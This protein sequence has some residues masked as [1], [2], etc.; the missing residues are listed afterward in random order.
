[1]PN[2][3]LSTVEGGLQGPTG[4]I[5]LFHSK[6]PTTFSLE[7]NVYTKSNVPDR[8]IPDFDTKVPAALKGIVSDPTRIPNMP[9]VD[10][11]NAVSGISTDGTMLRIEFVSNGNYRVFRKLSSEP[12]F[13]QIATKAG[14]AVIQNATRSFLVTDNLGS[15]VAYLAGCILLSN[16]NGVSWRELPLTVAVT[17]GSVI[18]L[19]WGS[20]G[21]LHMVARRE[22]SDTT[23]RVYRSTDKGESWV[24]SATGPS[25]PN[26]VAYVSGSTWVAV[27]LGV[28]TTHISTD[29]GITW[30][31]GAALPF[32][33]NANTS[34][35]QFFSTNGRFYILSLNTWYTGLTLNTMS[36]LGTD[37]IG[38]GV[39]ASGNCLALNTTGLYRY[40]ANGAAVT[41]INQKTIGL[42]S[43]QTGYS[44]AFAGGTW[45]DNHGSYITTT[46]LLAQ[47]S[48][49]AQSN[50]CFNQFCVTSASGRSILALNCQSFL[51]SDDNWNTWVIRK[52]DIATNTI[53]ALGQNLRVQ[54]IATDNN[55][56]WAVLIGG[57]STVYVIV[58]S[59]NGVTW[60]VRS[61][62]IG[63]GTS[64]S[65]AG[66]TLAG[67][68]YI[69]GS[70]TVGRFTSDAFLNTT[71]AS[72]GGNHESYNV[73]FYGGY[74]YFITS[75]GGAE[76]HVNTVKES[77]GVISV[78]TLGTDLS[79]GLG[80][81]SQH[82]FTY[83]NQAYLG[84]YYFV[85]NEGNATILKDSTFGAVNNFFD[86]NIN[87]F[88]SAVPLFQIGSKK[89][90]AVSTIVQNIS[91]VSF[92]TEGITGVT[93]GT[94]EYIKVS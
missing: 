3:S 92:Y 82:M 80:G 20:N 89:G 69:M 55:G 71:V 26:C 70:G 74:W 53:S 93:L 11:V 63:T 75:N 21:T 45:I 41:N 34:Q 94:N 61:V 56:G 16:D 62:V 57:N 18:D 14:S 68:Y 9:V 46:D 29:D 1:M 12:L 86:G 37:Y 59:D 13:S 42:S 31:T 60:V 54:G 87:G 43:A 72:Q 73:G 33:L 79:A 10:G 8:V 17:T 23:F 36:S 38:I 88:F 19:K 58:S 65:I 4:S 25:A 27:N 30:T 52:Y 15:W 7:G 35:N 32:N 40:S 44:L 24:K 5:A 77:T 50:N 47:K 22:T 28:S 85:V 48:F 83:K 67:R 84:G 39:D 66:G 90:L 49:T 2:F 81:S 51:Q 78:S 6:F 91:A 64:V 76:F